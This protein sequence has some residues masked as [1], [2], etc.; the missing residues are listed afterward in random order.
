MK[1]NQK[2]YYT[3]REALD[4]LGI[5][6]RTLARYEAAGRVKAYRRNSRDLWWPRKAIDKLG[7]F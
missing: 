6:R 3:T 2:D 5:S 7:E 1:R 4:I